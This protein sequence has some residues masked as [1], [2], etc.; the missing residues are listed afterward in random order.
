MSQNKMYSKS[1]TR[2]Y[3]KSILPETEYSFRP[4]IGRLPVNRNP[5]H[6]PIGEY[7]QY[8]GAVMARRKQVL[9]EVYNKHPVQYDIRLRR[10]ASKVM[11]KEKLKKYKELF[12]MF[13]NM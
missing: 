11:E 9:A 10:D 1:P 2:I 12:R 13:D 8:Q 7:L 6:K 4:K 3:H 5:D